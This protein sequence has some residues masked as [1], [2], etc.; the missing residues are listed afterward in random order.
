[1]PFRQFPGMNI[2][3]LG[4]IGQCGYPRM[5]RIKC[6]PSPISRFLQHGAN[7]LSAERP[8]LLKQLRA[9]L[10]LG[11]ATAVKPHGPAP[12]GC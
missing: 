9:Q 6:V 1:M 8:L 11:T 12:S 7:H 4:T 10:G 3:D 2:A 5:Q